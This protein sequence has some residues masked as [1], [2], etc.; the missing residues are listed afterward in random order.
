ME[1]FFLRHNGGSVWIEPPLGPPWTIHPCFEREQA[2]AGADRISPATFSRLGACDGLIVGVVQGSEVG[3]SRDP[4]V[5]RI[6][7][8]MN[9]DLV[10]VVKGGA[11]WLV[12]KLVGIVP[13]ARIIHPLD[14]SSVSMQIVGTVSGPSHI[15]GKGTGLNAPMSEAEAFKINMGIRHGSL[16][17]LQFRALLKHKGSGLSGKWKLTELL[18]LVPFLVGREFDRAVHATAIAVLEAAALHGDCSA[19]VNL[20]RLLPK[21][22]RKRFDRWLRIHSPISLDLTRRERKA[23]IVK[24]R[25]GSHHPYC[26]DLARVTAI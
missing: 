12:G 23:F 10:I 7:V 17:P 3:Q 14:D 22:K 4:T 25:D 20:A 11:D 13:F 24:A 9:A 1:V 2:A 19:A 6:A 18:A 21:P 26:L 16:T 5:L 8:G 15:I